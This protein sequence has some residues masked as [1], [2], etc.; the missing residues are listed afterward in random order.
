MTVALKI[1]LGLYTLQALIKFFNLFVV[2]YSF[3]IKRIAAIYSG[4]G[5][6][7]KVF[8]DVLLAF[9]VLLVAMLASAGLEHLSFITGL[10]V[11]LT[12]TQLLFH[13]FNRPL[14]ADKAPPPPVSPIK[15][16]SY[17]I[18]ATPALAWRELIVQTALFVWALYMLVTGA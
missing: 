6:S 3:R 2:P 5:R 17:A 13:R 12:L 1:L 15:S 8:D 14:D 7:V 9:T 4:G 18:Q 10:M 11:G 16:M